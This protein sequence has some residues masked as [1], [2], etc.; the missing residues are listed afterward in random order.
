MNLAGRVG[1]APLVL[2]VEIV[3]FV[4]AGVSAAEEDDTRA[5]GLAVVCDG[6]DRCDCDLACMECDLNNRREDVVDGA[7]SREQAIEEARQTALSPRNPCREAAAAP[8]RDAEL[9]G[10]EVGDRSGAAAVDR[11]M[12]PGLQTAG[13]IPSPDR[14]G[15]QLGSPIIQGDRDRASVRRNVKHHLREIAACNVLAPG[16]LDRD[17]DILVQLVIASSG[18]VTDARGLGFEPG[19]AA[20][21]AHVLQAIQFPRAESIAR[22][23]YPIEFRTK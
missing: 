5:D 14:G 11:S 4:V 15:V 22:I 1:F 8:W 21:A 7:M 23:D 17:G 9:W 19:V 6:P 12:R 18:T 2:A 13:R 10:T 20:C 16:S 3:V